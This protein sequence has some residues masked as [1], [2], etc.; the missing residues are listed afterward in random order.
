V[1]GNYITQYVAVLVMYKESLFGVTGT[2]VCTSVL[3]MISVSDNKFR[4]ES[5]VLTDYI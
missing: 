1:L 2:R 5:K 4:N 3:I